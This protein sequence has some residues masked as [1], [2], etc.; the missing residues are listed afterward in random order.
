MLPNLKF[1]MSL[2]FI[3]MFFIFFFKP[4][5]KFLGSGVQLFTPL[6]HLHG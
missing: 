6:D 5:L 2:C 3:N 1:H 4:I